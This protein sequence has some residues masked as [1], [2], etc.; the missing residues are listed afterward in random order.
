MMI[1]RMARTSSGAIEIGPSPRRR[2]IESIRTAAATTN[3][4]LRRPVADITPMTEPSQAT[5]S[6]AASDSLAG[7]E[8]YQIASTLTV[9]AAAVMSVAQRPA[10]S[11]RVTRATTKTKISPASGTPAVV[12]DVPNSRSLM[13]R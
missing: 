11:A 6:G 3:A 8:E 13:A 7:N 1:E 2:P 12:S 4:T 9:T 5:N 10:P